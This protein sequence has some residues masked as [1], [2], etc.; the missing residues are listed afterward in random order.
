MTQ[1]GA[2]PRGVDQSSVQHRRTSTR[3]L[4]F[5][6][7]SWA[8]IFVTFLVTVY[9]T[10]L[11]MGELGLVLA[12]LFY[13]FSFMTRFIVPLRSALAQVMTREAAA[14]LSVGDR[15]R[16]RV[17]FSNAVVLATGMALLT[18]VGVGL[19]T[20]FVAD[21]FPAPEG[22]GDKDEFVRLARIA[23]LCEGLI[24]ASVLFFNPWVNLYLATQRVLAEN[25]ARTTERALDLV[26]AALAFW[27]LPRLGMFEGVHVF[28][29]FV[30]SRA[31]LRVGQ[32]AA[33][34]AIIRRLVRAARFRAG[35]VS[36]REMR[37]I[38]AVGGWSLS[39]AA[40][41]MGFYAVDQPFVYVFFGPVYNAIF[42]VVTRLQGMGQMLGGNISFG[43]EAMSADHHQLGR[44]E[45]NRRIL[46]TSMRLTSTIS[47]MCTAA[48]VLLCVPIVDVWLGRELRAD[49]DL[50]AAMSYER[51]LWLVGGFTAILLPSVWFSQAML[52]ST[53]VLYGMGLIR[54]YSP[55]MIQAAVGKLILAWVGLQFFGAGPMW[56]VWST[57]IA[58]VWCFGVMFPSLICSVFEM[59]R[60]E[61]AMQVYGR[62][63]LS[64]VAPTIGLFAMT[65]VVG[66]WDL[67][68]LVAALAL[69]GVLYAPGFFFIGLDG[70]ER[71]RLMELVN[72]VWKRGPQIVMNKARRVGRR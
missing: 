10:K 31:A 14:A 49:P 55:W 51:A 52:V 72:A 29:L 23:V 39:N 63:V 41:N 42:A 68:M 34:S 46:L 18:L 13:M 4:L 30:A 44:H 40:A 27:V 70:H 12:G 38:G 43:V 15:E 22:F 20:V 64:V 57:V 50:M 8:R 45:L 65:R 17:V 9:L 7:S 37:E 26:A 67:T 6:G 53:K 56:V 35:L 28:V 66:E 33:R 48:V 58:Q 25:V 54:R 16:V 24:A 60:R 21:I 1:D 69:G 59:R 5:A 3:L 11:L 19:L 47:A 36:R 2:R 62:P 71:R 61:L 32:Q